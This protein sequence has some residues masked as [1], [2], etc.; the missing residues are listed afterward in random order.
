MAARQTTA[1][2]FDEGSKGFLV[3]D[4]II[5]NTSGEPIRFNQTGP[6]N[7]TFNNN[8]FGVAPEDPAFPKARAAEA[9]PRQQDETKS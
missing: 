5:H 1:F 7:L 6:E 2:F 8:A 4:N 9:G 3:E